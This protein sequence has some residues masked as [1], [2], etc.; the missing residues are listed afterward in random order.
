MQTP[1][2]A[3]RDFD[4]RDRGAPNVAIVNQ[5]FGARY[6]PNRNPIGQ[7]LSATVTRPPSDLQI[8]GVVKDVSTRSLRL[9]PAP[10]VYVSYFQRES[11][12]DALVIRA[13]GSLSQAASAIRKQLQPNFFTTAVEVHALVDQVERTLVWERLMM[14][15][16][17]G[18]GALGLALACVGLYGLLGYAVVRRTRE[19]GI[20][21]AL[22]AQQR[23]VR[24]MIVQRA[25]RLL[26]AG[27]GVGVLAAWL[28]SR[29]L[30][31]M[32]FGL[33]PMD[34]SV[35][36]GGVVLLVLAGIL[37]AYFPARRATRVDPITALRH[38]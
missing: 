11:R 21:M 1:L 33:T 14:T 35:I 28:V 17:G 34:P 24:W 15:L 3:G 31:S 8:V 30:Q 18:F 7:Y 13:S 12:T 9:P 10:T 36:A 19:I 2:L 32:L 16:T 5:A 26:V 25:L 23:G 38:E 4:E 6:F 37:A 29:W 20:R 27:V 22:G